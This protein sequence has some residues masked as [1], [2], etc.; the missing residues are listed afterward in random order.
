MEFTVR[1]YGKREFYN[2]L[3]AK[4]YTMSYEFFRSQLIVALEYKDE[5][6]HQF[7]KRR[8]LHAKEVETYIDEVGIPHTIDVSE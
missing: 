4:G 7:K 8:T 6:L 1:P 3:V 2:L 5:K